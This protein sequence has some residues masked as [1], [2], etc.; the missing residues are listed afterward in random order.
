M[1]DFIILTTNI[2]SLNYSFPSLIPTQE[3]KVEMTTS[4]RTLRLDNDPK[5]IL[6]ETTVTAFSSNE[7]ATLNFEMKTITAIELNLNMSD[8]EINNKCLPF[9][10]TAVNEKIKFITKCVGA[11]NIELPPAQ[12]V[13]KNLLCD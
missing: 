9:V 3:L 7:I 13:V 10:I 4:T 1:I 6:I 11:P 8:A 12:I 2:E 5:K